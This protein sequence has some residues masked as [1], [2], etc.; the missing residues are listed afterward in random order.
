M[1]GVIIGGFIRALIIGVP[2]AAMMVCLFSGGWLTVLGIVLLLIGLNLC[3]GAQKFI[4][5]Q[6][7]PLQKPCFTSSADRFGYYT[8]C[9]FKI[10]ALYLFLYAPIWIYALYKFL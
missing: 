3:A 8:V 1:I 10:L 5:S 2:I 9:S 4:D 6:K 7:T